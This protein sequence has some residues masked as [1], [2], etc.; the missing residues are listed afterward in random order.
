MVDVTTTPPVSPEAAAAANRWAAG[1]FGAPRR[2]SSLITEVAVNDEVIH[3]VFTE[4]V[5]VELREE[6][7]PASEGRS[8]A[9]RTELG[10]VNPFALSAEALRAETTH[11]AACATCK[12][13]GVAPCPGCRGSGRL[14]CPACNGATK[15]RNPATNRLNKCKECKATGQVACRSC[16]A[17]GSAACQTCKGS[18]HQRVWLIGSESR[19]SRVVVL[20]Q[21]PVIAAHRQLLEPRMV[22]A[23]DVSAFTIGIDVTT[24]GP[25]TPAQLDLEARA[26]VSAQLATIDPRFERVVC[27]QYIRLAILRRD[28]AYEMCGTR[29]TLVLSGRELAGATTPEALGPI[30]RRLYL[31]P[32]LA[33][34]VSVCSAMPASSTQGGHSAYFAGVNGFNGALWF[35]AAVLCA[36]WSGALLRAW[37][38]GMHV[39]R[40]S[41]AELVVCAVWAGALTTMA[42]AGL[43]VRPG[44]DEVPAA[45]A[46]GDVQ[47]ARVVI[48]ALHETQGAS[49]A[50]LAAEDMVLMAEANAAS[51]KER[52]AKLDEVTSHHGEQ[53]GVA[54]V[55]ARA[56][57]LAQIRALID[58]RRADEA[59]TLIDRWFADS[60]QGDPEVAECRALASEL[61]AEECRHDPCRFVVASSAVA[62]HRTP[63]RIA[64][65]EQVRARIADALTIRDVISAP[66]AAR[67]H[68]LGVVVALADQTIEH[69]K[70]DS[71]L[72][73]KALS[74]KSRASE[75][76]AIAA[77]L[78]SDSTVIHELFPPLHLVGAGVASVSLEG[79]EVFFSF[80]AAGKCSGIYAVGPSGHRGLHSEAWP[81]DRILSQAFGRPV[82]VR[83]PL[84]AGGTISTWKEA[85]TKIVARWRNGELVELRIGSAAA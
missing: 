52:L 65:V 18:G 78:G 85:A 29:G 1:V 5:R 62:A 43:V 84:E 4:V 39:R 63:A 21:S 40:L 50:V 76:R 75:E 9:P 77:V 82:T 70:D 81:A 66:D 10:K 36:W 6:R 79:T 15:V 30:R 2:F 83:K 33:L 60:W 73:A 19:T 47:R 71:D 42:I 13:S 12:A 20:P 17:S 55:E 46:A 14:V 32:V 3:R 28:V 53:A 23:G 11:I 68:E 54:A 67:L 59:I 31:W 8:S 37:R 72:A 49:P 58:G 69:V 48:D 41:K 24:K 56:D 25:L 64:A 51:G 27:Q 7:A 57:R 26:V 34:M 38:P 16:N 35:S 74:A 44:L 61:R 80:D 45:L 22:T